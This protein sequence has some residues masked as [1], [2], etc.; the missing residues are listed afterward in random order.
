MMYHK[1]VTSKFEM[2]DNLH[3]LF[4]KAAPKYTVEKHDKSNILNI[5][6]DIKIYVTRA[7][8]LLE[9]INPNCVDSVPLFGTSMYNTLVSVVSIVTSKCLGYRAEELLRD[10]TVVL[11][12]ELYP[13]HHDYLN[14]SQI[15]QPYI[16][17][18]KLE[19]FLA[20]NPCS[21]NK[22][23]LKKYN[24]EQRKQVKKILRSISGGNGC[25]SV[26][27]GNN[28]SVSISVPLL[29]KNA[30]VLIH[31]LNYIIS[32]LKELERILVVDNDCKS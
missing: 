10:M 11:F 6:G 3:F 31:T 12:K 9:I 2:L 24:K 22:E 14:N 27:F 5:N 4:S 20:Y 32:Q 8:L 23:H 13:T 21:G 29:L 26:C 28:S 7:G 1:N 18:D 25:V 15:C 19:L 17:V 16:T 30:S